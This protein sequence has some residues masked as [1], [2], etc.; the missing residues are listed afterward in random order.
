MMRLLC[1]FFWAFQAAAQ[2]ESISPAGTELT[3]T[4]HVPQD[5]ADSGKGPIFF[6]LNTTSPVQWFALGQ[7]TQM[8]GANMF[9]VYTSA[10]GNNNVTVSPRLGQGH[11]MPEHN[12][13]ADVSVLEGSGFFNDE[14][15]S[16]S[17]RCDSCISW[18]GG[19]LDVTSASSPWIWAVKYGTPLGSD[20][21][22]AGISY[23]DTQGTATVNLEKA[24]GQLSASSDS[25]ANP[26]LQLS[27]ATVSSAE[28]GAPFDTVALNR[29]KLA[30]AILMTLV[31]VVFFP[32]GALALYVF[33]STIVTH[34]TLQLF[35]LVI[36][37]AGLG[38]G[39][40]MAKQI[41]LS[42]HHHPIIG[43]V[44]VIGLVVL[45]P[46]MGLLQHRHYRK[47]VG[48]G[49]SGKGPF[50]YLH[51][52]FGR[53]M[54]VLGIINMGL[55]FRLTGFQ[56]PYAPRGAVIACSV[57]AGVVA[58]VY[59]AIL[60][61]AAYLHRKSHHNKPSVH[62]TY[63][64]GIQITRQFLYYAS[65]H[66]VEDIQAF[67]SQWVPSPHWVR[68]ETVAIPD[69]YLSTAA[70]AVMKQL[71][72]KGIVRVGG[73]QWWQ[74]RGPS[75]ELKGEWV[76]MRSHHN[77][78]KKANAK[79]NRIMLYIHG[80]AYFFGSVD[81][82][83]YM[84]QR[85][86]R[87]LK[88]RVFAPEYRLSPQF[89]FP[90]AIQDCLASYLWLLRSY[91]PT[92]II[93]AG[94]SAGGGM[95]LSLMVI[96]RDQGIPLPAGAILISPWVDLTHSMPSIVEDNPGDYIPPNGFRHKPSTAWP[97]PNTDEI[98]KIKKLSH[99]P[100]ITAK[101]VNETIPV[102]NSNAEETAVQGYTLHAKKEVTPGHAYPGMQQS[103]D[104]NTVHA[105][106]DN[107][108]VVL[109]GKTVELKDQI[110]MYTT[111][112]LISHPLVS[113]ILQPSLGGLPPLQILSGG[114]EMLRDEQFY[115]AHKAANPKLYPPSD[116]YLDEFDPDRKTLNKYEPTYVHF[117][118]WDNLCHVAPTFSFSRPAKYMFRAISQFGSWALARAQKHGV[119]I[120]DDN[121]V[122]SVSSSGTESSS[123]PG[124]SKGQ[125]IPRTETGM[126]FVGKAGDPLPAFHQHM[127]RERVDKRG[128]TFPLDPPSS[129][130]VLDIPHEKIGAVNP[131]LIKKW[132]DAKHEWDT[133]FAKEK[134]R[135]QGR[136][137]KEMAHGFQDF[138]GE[139]P[140]P[141]SLAA[142]RAAPGVLP[143]RHAKKN[144]G[145]MLWSG[146]GSKHDERTLKKEQQAEQSGRRSTRTSVDAGQAG[147]YSSEPAIAQQSGTDKD[148][149]AAASSA[150][151]AS[152]DS[153]GEHK[154]STGNLASRASGY[155]ESA[156]T[157][158][159]SQKSGGPLLI[160][161][162]VDNRKLK[163][164][165]AST[166]AL[167][168]AAMTSNSSL[169]QLNGR[170]S[171]VAGRSEFLSDD[172]STIGGERDAGTSGVTTDAVS[173]RAV[174]SAKGV[175][176]LVGG[177]DSGR[178]S[179]ETS[180]VRAALSDG[181]ARE[182]TS[183]RPEMPDREVFKTADEKL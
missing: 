28:S 137:I 43:L 44:V 153:V 84:M 123:S 61:L 127:L 178:L 156:P 78:T 158:P 146:W 3:F 107:I 124:R 131:E 174:L 142:R 94:D 138:N 166:R 163:D 132:L 29:K 119:D 101:E 180:S 152:W 85:H 96:M 8:R 72:P 143:N 150:G 50:A 23:H 144:Y 35:N 87:K 39:V 27:S 80:G 95:A 86:A 73:E 100:T 14:I 75:E 181:E 125:K 102:A 17:I 182:S 148:S 89:P 161:P 33:P 81:T 26:F 37:I 88:G 77:E 103:S 67:T 167:F 151:V 108:H 111:N 83:R 183:R 136:R 118:L 21:V 64:E 91:D 15:I 90:C 154:Q 145:L 114:G 32:F 52:W 49:S 171:S 58:I 42:N 11:V 93:I 177:G 41:Q 46:A 128:R 126:S 168:H 112:Q 104:S 115:V 69:E 140:P 60:V 66:P 92:E 122:S 62:I 172:A 65:K 164:E 18:D 6:Q 54:I 47:S 36:A 135:V 51:R 105:E 38:I 97:P 7:G 169:P 157:R 116:V 133:K 55:G 141:S 130:P 121:V 45:Q 34:A 30:H 70:Q 76:E 16:A 20:S 173:T 4:I 79:S 59:I 63:D 99:K 175:V 134:L 68:T 117:Q 40:S 113:P 31:F 1:W 165:N 159:I 56:D 149:Q 82:H 155:P 170:P 10:S 139:C 98:L 48:D 22:S 109:E 9:V 110:Q 12:A 147:T 162:E 74:W 129:Y 24:T 120:V 106:P 25:N 2:F 57:V 5:T 19:S 176:G 53:M 71:G 160:L 179:T 13:D